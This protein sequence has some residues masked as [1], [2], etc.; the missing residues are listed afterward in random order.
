MEV[1]LKCTESREIYPLHWAVEIVVGIHLHVF[2]GLYYGLEFKHSE[3]KG[4]SQ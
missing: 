3:N 2:N 4:F 1:T